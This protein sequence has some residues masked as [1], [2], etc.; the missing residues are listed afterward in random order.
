MPPF[1]P[2]AGRRRT[3]SPTSAYASGNVCPGSSCSR[4]G[5]GWGPA[6]PQPPLQGPHLYHMPSPKRFLAAKP[7]FSSA[8]QVLCRTYTN[9]T[10]ASWPRSAVGYWAPGSVQQELL[11][12]GRTLCPR[13][14]VQPCPGGWGRGDQGCSAPSQ[15]RANSCSLLCLCPNPPAPSLEVRGGSWRRGARGDGGTASRLPDLPVPAA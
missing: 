6:E 13:V 10:H 14:G 3:C 15:P 1:T 7:D 2:Q 9:L 11:T 5:R 8:G 4:A 12:G